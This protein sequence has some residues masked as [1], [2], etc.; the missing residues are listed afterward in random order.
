VQEREW[1]RKKEGRKKKSVAA[2]VVH[3]ESTTPPKKATRPTIARRALAGP[4][5]YTTS[6]IGRDFMQIVRIKYHHAS[7]EEEKGVERRSKERG[8]RNEG[9]EKKKMIWEADRKN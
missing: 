3:F 4:A 5:N 8:G 1:G 2:S 6:R 9:R 7:Q